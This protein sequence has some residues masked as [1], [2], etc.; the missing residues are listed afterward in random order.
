MLCA[1]FYVYS[2]SNAIKFTPEGGSIDIEASWLQETNSIEFNSELTSRY[3]ALPQRACRIKAEKPMV[4]NFMLIEIVL[5][6]EGFVICEE[7]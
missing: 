5:L 2:I 1:V 7:I 3:A 4:E 6:P